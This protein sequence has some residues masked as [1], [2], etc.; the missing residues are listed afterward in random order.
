MSNIYLFYFF[1]KTSTG[2]ITINTITNPIS[3]MPSVEPISET[4]SAIKVGVICM[5]MEA[6]CGFCA[7]VTG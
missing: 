2:M 4:P 6:V 3:K 1:L 5:D 7:A